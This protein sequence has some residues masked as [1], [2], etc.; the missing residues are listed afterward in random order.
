M[1]Q[2]PFSLL[3]V[4]LLFILVG[5]PSKPPPVGPV[6]PNPPAKSAIE[7]QS[8]T[9]AKP[10]AG[11]QVEAVLEKP[12]AGS[13][14]PLASWPKPTAVLV[15]TGQ[16]LG[17]IEPCGC[18]GLE[19][20][21]GGLARRHTFLRELQDARGWEVVPLD[22][23][24]QV[25]RFGKQQELKFGHTVTALRQ[26]QYRAVGFGEGD[27]R[28]TPGEL[29]A[30]IAGPDGTV[31][32]FV[33]GNVAV[34]SRDLQPRYVVIE[35][36]G[37]R[38]GVTSI[39]GSKYESRLQGDELVHELPQPALEEIAKELQSKHCDF[40]V[41]LVSGSMEEA[42]ALAKATP[43]F[44][45]VAASGD[46]S[47]AS[48]EL[49]EIPGTKARLMQVGHKSTHV[50]VVGLLADGK[51]SVRYESVPLDARF[52]DS[53]EMLQMLASYQDELKELGLEG[54][55]IKSQ[56]HPSGNKFVGSEKC[57]ECH[58]KAFEKWSQTPH[59]HALDSLVM[60]PN[61]RGNIARHFDP[62]C[63]SCHVTGWDPQQY[64]PFDTGYTSLE[65][66]P[67][68]RH[69]G[70]E[71]CHGPG[72]AHVA[73][74]SGEGDTGAATIAKLREAMKLPLA[75]GVAER[76]CIECHDVDNSPDFHKEGA[77][78]RY[79]KKVEHIGKD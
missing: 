45:L 64:Y 29:L 6:Q 63:L 41:L 49:E 15:V 78:E 22:V 50:G 21:K 74:E 13:A 12:A 53:P 30:A 66:T 60:P 32:D 72:S 65:R 55:G 27:L 28:L 67:Q 17:Y 24:G 57:G 54:L 46:T 58:G 79:W 10:V 51:Q 39:V 36:G 48:H 5:C 34:L 59:A 33:G 19:N 68:L 38:I 25:K 47:I 56:P 20:Q 37:K 31:S 69:S 73:A 16:Q 14:K 7:P 44:D 76:K 75:G 42:R 11:D 3:I 61:T 70:C 9:S 1:S 8:K 62:E 77:F 2:Q 23:G 4:P 26:M 35:A 52:E 71:N 18:T 40:Q 43:I